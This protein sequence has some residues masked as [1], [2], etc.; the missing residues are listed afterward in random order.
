MSRCHRIALIAAFCASAIW[1]AACGS[2]PHPSPSPTS[3]IQADSP[4]AWVQQEVAW[5]CLAAGDAHPD[6][7]NWVLTPASRAAR[8]EGRRTSYLKMYEKSTHSMAYVAVV[9]GDFSSAAERPRRATTLYLVVRAEQHDY[10]AHGLALRTADLSGLGAAHSYV[11]QVPLSAGVWG[12]TFSAGGP[13]PGGPFPIA[14]A[15]VAV[16]AGRRAA[17]QPLETLRS[18]ENGFFALDLEPG[19][20]TFLLKERN[21]GFP[22]PATV[23][24]VEGTPV[25]AAVVGS[26]V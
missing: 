18:D 7:C 10:L 12:H 3:S 6:Q 11:P 1:L 4:P 8:S 22:I 25:A 15:S 21:R 9:R 16:W 17:G 26:M 23:T 5:Q 19:V 14:N 20:Y 24:V 2:S 13:F